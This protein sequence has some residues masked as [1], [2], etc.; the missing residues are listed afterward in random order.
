[1]HPQFA[2]LTPRWFHRAFVYTGSIG[3]FRYRFAHD[4][5]TTLHAA[6]YSRVCYEAAGDVHQRDFP[7]NDEGVEALKRWLQT[8]YDAF[9]QTGSF[10]E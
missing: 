6:V 4:D 9:T 7:W 8:Q 10:A 2:E 5:N 3:D 1:M